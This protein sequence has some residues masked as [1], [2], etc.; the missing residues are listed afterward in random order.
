MGT[1]LGSTHRMGEGDTQPDSG[2]RFPPGSYLAPMIDSV[3]HSSLV[4]ECYDL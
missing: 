1:N 2:D 3:K 4:Q